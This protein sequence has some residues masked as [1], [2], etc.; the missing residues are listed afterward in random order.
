MPVHTAHIRS[1]VPAENLLEFPPRDGWKPLC[2]FLGKD[3]PRNVPFPYVNKGGNA[4]NIIKAAI[5]I[6]FVKQEF[7]YFAGLGVLWVA[8]KW[9][10]LRL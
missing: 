10:L 1:L 8:W 5:M 6:W 7:P 3:V 9:S 4:A 2:Q